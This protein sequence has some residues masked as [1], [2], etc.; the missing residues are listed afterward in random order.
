MDRGGETGRNLAHLE[1]TDGPESYQ[2]EVTRWKCDD[3]C[4]TCRQNNNNITVVESPTYKARFR[5]LLQVQSGGAV[6]IHTV[7]R[8]Q[9]TQNGYD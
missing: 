8:D 5:V 2:E 3:F 7:T 6:V 4:N 9:H 1:T